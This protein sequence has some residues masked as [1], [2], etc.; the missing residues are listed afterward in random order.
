[1][2]A[3]SRPYEVLLAP[4]GTWLLTA[5]VLFA[6]VC[7]G[8]D[9]CTTSRSHR[10]RLATLACCALLLLVA[11]GQFRA[12]S[13][14]ATGLVAMAHALALFG[15]ARWSW[16]VAHRDERILPVW[17]GLLIAAAALMPKC[18]A[19]GAWPPDL[20]AYAAATGYVGLRTLDGDWPAQFFRGKEL[21]LV[22]GGLSPLM[23]PVLRVTMG[24]FG[25]TVFAI[26]L[27]EVLGSTLLLVVLWLWLRR[28]VRGGWGLVA[29]AAFAFSPWHLA[30]ARMG[31]IFSISA[32]LA[33]A[34]LW[35]GERV[36]GEGRPR[37]AWWLAFGFGTGLIGYAYAPVK[38]LYPFAAAVITAGAWRLRQRAHR[39]WWAPPLLAVVPAGLVLA[40]QIGDAARLD[41]MFR[42]DFGDLATDTAIWHKTTDDQ[43]TSERQPVRVIAENFFR[44]AGTWLQTI[45][46]ERDILPWYA[47]ALTLG[48]LAMLVM[49]LRGRGWVLPAYALFG[50]LPP[51]II[52]PLDRRSLIAWPLVYVFGVVAVRELAR[53]AADLYPRRWWRSA[54][55][56]IVASGIAAAGAYGL[57]LFAATNSIVRAW[58]YFGPDHRLAMLREAEAL[59]PSCYVVFVN[60]DNM[61]APVVEVHFYEP[62]RSLQRRHHWQYVT[63]D[64]RDPELP[65]LP[66]GQRL[67]FVYLSDN[68]RD[69]VMEKLTTLL[70]GGTLIRRVAPDDSGEVHHS[71]Y[72]YD[73]AA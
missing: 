38:V 59:L 21:D 32:A 42:T 71:L 55:H 41:E 23:L 48:A 46:A 11:R 70:P 18:I 20:N 73:G 52:Y 24:I 37:V 12:D 64:E 4:W 28:H 10:G 16:P 15:L 66:E 9:L 68:G 8:L 1:M 29:L 22:N 26:R 35:T 56:A 47:P 39:R 65:E 40:V 3:L 36:L 33:L 62:A 72:L 49:L 5:Y 57:H 30:Q 25:G 34:L 69:D 7:V 53:R 63:L 19:L 67:C 17:T 58:P 50:L 54:C 45:Y 31:T 6:A 61:I 27:S 51:L 43:V 14:A 60:L 44:N 2:P 13:A